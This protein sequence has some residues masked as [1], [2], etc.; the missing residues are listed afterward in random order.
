MPEGDTIYRTAVTL[1]RVLLGKAITKCTSYVA[2]VRPEYLEGK[3]VSKVD[4][5]GKNLLIHFNNGPVLHTH[6]RMSG[7][8]HIYRLGEKWRMSRKAARLVLEVEDFQAVC[9]N[10]QDILLRTSLRSKKLPRL[11]PDALK[12]TNGIQLQSG[13]DF[14]SIQT[15]KLVT[16]F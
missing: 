13:K 6:M 10:A 1:S 9:F 15:L 4:S 12:P 3:I 5:Q 11:G 7:S 14:E 16:L 8:W 2:D